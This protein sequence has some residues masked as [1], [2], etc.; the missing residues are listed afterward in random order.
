MAAKAKT[1]GRKSKTT[2]QLAKA[3]KKARAVRWAL[4]KRA[5]TPERKKALTKRLN[6]AEAEVK[7]LEGCVSLQRVVGSTPHG[8]A[9]AL[10]YIDESSGEFAIREFDKNGRELAEAFGYIEAQTSIDGP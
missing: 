5:D 1:A 6:E 7:K 2:P 3:R 8:G 10:I 4:N 9:Y